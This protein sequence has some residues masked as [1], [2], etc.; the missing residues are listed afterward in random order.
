MYIHISVFVNRLIVSQKQDGG[1]GKQRPTVDL[2]RAAW[3]LRRGVNLLPCVLLGAVV[4]GFQPHEQQAQ[5]GAQQPSAPPAGFTRPAQPYYNGRG[6]PR[7]G[8]RGGRGG[9]I[10]GY[11]GGASNGFRGTRLQPLAVFV[12][13]PSTFF[14]V[15]V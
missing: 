1:K 6:A 4:G 11:R 2:R 7:G 12:T 10:N 15:N 14:A 13:R 8:P 5:A 3:F 9:I